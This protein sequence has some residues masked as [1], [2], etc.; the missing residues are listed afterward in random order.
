M[1]KFK[2]I[3]KE[4]KGIKKIISLFYPIDAITSVEVKRNKETFDISKIV[5]KLNKKK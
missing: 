3:T 1:R 5:L 4:E 2:I